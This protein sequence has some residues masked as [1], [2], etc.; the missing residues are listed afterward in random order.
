LTTLATERYDSLFKHYAYLKAL[1]WRLLKAQAVAESELNPDARSPVGAQG[2]CQFMP[3]TFAEVAQ[4]L[5]LQHPDV[6]NPEQSIRCQAAMMADLLHRF[7]PI[8][9]ALAAY[10]WGEGHV[11]KLAPWN[12]AQTPP[13]T[14]LYVAHILA[15][16]KGTTL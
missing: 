10:N 16:L 3:A 1:D 11:A 6:W 12:L 7:P 15:L 4:N 2:L 5:R 13:E 8:E 9:R 14:K